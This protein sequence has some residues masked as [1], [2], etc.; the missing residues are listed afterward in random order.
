MTVATGNT[1]R[2]DLQVIT[3]KGFTVEFMTI[4]ADDVFLIR[5]QRRKLSL[6]RK[7]AILAIFSNRIM[8]LLLLHFIAQNIVA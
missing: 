5:E 4:P 6:V 7:M 3:G 8:N 2:L 1:F